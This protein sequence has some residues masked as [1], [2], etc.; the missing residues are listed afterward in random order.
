MTVSLSTDTYNGVTFTVDGDDF[1]I[2][3]QGGH[4]AGDKLK[5]IQ[6]LR[7]S[8]HND[9]LI[10]SSSSN[11]LEGRGGADT[12]DAGDGHAN[13]VHY[14]HSDQGVIVS[15]DEGKFTD[16]NFN[17]DEEVEFT[18]DGDFITG[19]QGG[20]AAGDRLKG[21]RDIIGSAHDDWLI[22]DD[23]NNRI[24]GLD[25][26]D[27]LMG[28]DGN[29]TLT[30]GAGDDIFV[31]DL[32]GNVTNGVSDSK[33]RIDDFTQ[34]EDQLRIDL[35]NAPSSYTSL[36]DAGITTSTSGGN[37]TISHDGIEIATLMGFEGTLTLA[38]FDIV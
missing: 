20:H 38:D 10:G 15:L 36:A 27:T 9:W 24:S 12:L 18:K 1:I 37:T 5:N 28:L 29:D 32:T 7:G 6:N 26:N 34:G 13:E 30:G 23:S 4:A 11:S 17:N 8:D 3:H 35:S 14:T 16:S 21:F 2:G 25:G 31:L 22:G 33:D 19:H